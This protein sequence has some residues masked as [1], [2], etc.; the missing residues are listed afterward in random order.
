MLYSF[1]HS[2]IYTCA[3][4]AQQAGSAGPARYVQKLSTVSIACTKKAFVCLP[5]KQC[6]Q[7]S[8]SP[9]QGTQSPPDAL[10]I[11][12]YTQIDCI[13]FWPMRQSCAVHDEHLKI[14]QA[15][16]KRLQLDSQRGCYRPDTKVRLAQTKRYI[17][18]AALMSLSTD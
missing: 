12:S 2:F 7:S 6:P 15:C 11:A 5:P 16:W 1:I 17:W 14:S 13:H 3:R 18:A 10:Q 9:S 8:F 4:Q